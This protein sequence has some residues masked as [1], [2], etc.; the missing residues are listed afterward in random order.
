MNSRP[1]VLREQK[2][3]T[4]LVRGERVSL[5]FSPRSDTVSLKF[6]DETKQKHTEIRLSR[7]ELCE[8]ED[9][10]AQLRLEMPR[11]DMRTARAPLN[12]KKF[13]LDN[14]LF[15]NWPAR[16]M[17]EQYRLE[18]AMVSVEEII[19]WRN[20]LKNRPRSSNTLYSKLALSV[21]RLEL[22]AYCRRFIENVAA[23]V[24]RQAPDWFASTGRRAALGYIEESL[25]NAYPWDVDDSNGELAAARAD[26]LNELLP[27]T[28]SAAKPVDRSLPRRLTG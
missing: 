2:G 21:T 15:P 4:F 17:A 7:E 16:A 18:K 28:A 3:G 27:G 13:V 24:E 10:L 8:L 1:L 11:I 20:T 25:V 26:A 19:E 6:E 14:S 12:M 9:A 23:T 22:E 5:G